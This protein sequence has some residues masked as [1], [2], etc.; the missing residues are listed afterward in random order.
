VNQ[1]LAMH[2]IVVA[3]SLLQVPAG[4]QASVEQI[5]AGFY[6]QRLAGLAEEASETVERRQ[7][8]AVL[9]TQPS[10][11]PQTI[12]A[13]YTNTSSAAI[14]VLQAD[15]AGGFQIAAEPP[16]NLDIFGSV[17]S[18]TLDDLDGDGRK[19]IV[20]AFGMMNSHVSWVFRWDGHQL[21][22]L[23][24]LAANGDGTQYSELSN[25]ELVDVDNDRI[26][27]MYVAGAKPDADEGPAQPD[28]IYRLGTDGFVKA[29]SLI[30]LWEFQRDTRSPETQRVQVDL[31][32]G[33]L[34]P[35]MLHVINGDADGHARV[36]SAQV[37]FNDRLVVTP[38]DVNQQVDVLDRSVTFEEHNELAVR[39]A[40]APGSKLLVIL[41]SRGWSQ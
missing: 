21:L 6:P 39:L 22:N 31:P 17:C 30:G 2:P 36:S 24:P 34:G 11:G 28:T 3:L 27:E 26:P 8:H 37:W 9:D 1:F 16:A 41:R 23:T 33:A 18:I 20:V 35:Y 12:V 25:A 4:P 7:C 15:G 13:A 29:E 19:E 14:R 5:V 32:E 40:G 10:G 38:S